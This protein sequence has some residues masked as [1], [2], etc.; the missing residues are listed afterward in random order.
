MK[1]NKTLKR[2][3][4]GSAIRTLIGAAVF[5]ASIAQAENLTEIYTKALENDHQFRAAHAA[6]MAGLEN[7]AIGR[8]NLLPS[9]NASASWE[10]STTN[11]VGVSDSELLDTENGS[12]SSG[13]SI[14]LEQPLFD[15]AAW[16]RFKSGAANADLAEAQFEADKQNLI[17][18]AA[19]AYFDT[20]LAVDSLE[21]ARAE[22]NA[23]SHQLEQTR[24]RFE[25]G[26]TAITEV[27]EAQAVYDSAV[28]DRLLIEGQLGIAF[29]SLEV[30]TG[31]SFEFLSPLKDNFPVTLPE[32]ASRED[33]EKRALANNY[34]LQ[35]AS[36]RAE[37]SRQ[38]AKASK[39]GH[40]PRLSGSL[41]YSDRNSDSEFTNTAGI[42]NPSDI[43]TERQAIGITLTV[44]IYNGGG[45]SAS[46]RQANQRYIQARENFLQ[47]QR[48]IIQQ[49]RSQHLLV[50]TSVATVKARK[51]AITSNESALEATRAGYE[52]GTRDLVDVLN[53]QR[54]LFRAKRNYYDALY[55]YILNSLQLK[56][57]AGVLTDEGLGELNVWLDNMNPAYKTGRGDS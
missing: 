15:M 32:P 4:L 9:L 28:A 18:R 10:D 27:H 33:W 5:S 22:E 42:L 55:T 25:V 48:D 35:V 36:L 50:E 43:D 11:Q 51:Q 49:V 39:A 20:L 8:S 1:T 6:Y 29:E 40:Y 52:V 14:T 46:R 45:T 38:D 2:S 17:I 24:Q 23:L 12:I 41:S 47:T 26:L 53:A 3:L 7:K 16:A 30:I 19:Q 56:S 31:E 21:T 37:A 44:P 57:T 34:N 54:N 13:Y